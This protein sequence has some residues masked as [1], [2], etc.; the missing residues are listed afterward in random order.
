MKKI[1]P[2]SAGSLLKLTVERAMDAELEASGLQEMPVT[3]GSRVLV[4]EDHS[5]AA[6]VARGV[7]LELNCQVDIAPDGKT[8]LTL[9]EE[10]YYDLIL[11]DIRLPDRDGCDVTRRIR[12]KQWQ[13]NP[14]VPIVGLTAHTV[15]SKKKSCLENGMNS[16]YSKPLTPEKASEILSVF[17][18]HSQSS[19]I[20]IASDK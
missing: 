10:N 1:Y 9:V 4:V 20:L 7:L 12:L 5:I 19:P 14:S 2:P 17:L 8:A 11:M 13:S 15:E 3:T 6:K 18:S 16:I